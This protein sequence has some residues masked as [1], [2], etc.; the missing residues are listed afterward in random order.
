MLSPAAHLRAGVVCLLGGIGVWGVSAWEQRRNGQETAARLLAA[1]SNQDDLTEQQAT[2]EA[3]AQL[4]LFRSSSYARRAFLQIALANPPD[5]RR[6]KSREQ[7]FEIS[8]SRVRSS[9]AHE[10]FE[11]AI[12]PAVSSSTDPDILRE[13][14][15]LMERW[16]IAGTL[17]PAENEKLA[18]TSVA[19]MLHTEDTDQIGALAYGVTEVAA[20]VR[21]AAADDLASQL[22]SRSLEDANASVN[23]ARLPALLALE[24]RLSDG[25]AAALAVQLTDRIAQEHNGNALRTLA[26]ESRGLVEKMSAPVAEGM[27]TKIVARIAAEMNPGQLGPLQSL[28]EPVRDKIGSDKA[29]ELVLQ[30]EPRI[31]LESNT[32][33]LQ[34][35]MAAWRTLASRVSGDAAQPLA[36]MLLQRMNMPA[37]ALTLSRLASALAALNAT[38]D[39]FQHAGEILIAHMRT[40]ANGDDLARLGAAVAAMRK[41][42]PEE[43]V[44]EAAGILVRRMIAESDAGAIGEMA[45]ALD[46]LDEGVSARKAY[47]F[48]TLIEKRMVSDSNSEALLNLASGFL[49]V[50][51]RAGD[52]AAVGL[53]PPLLARIRSE[54]RPAVLRT[55]A[56]CIGAFS[57]ELD[58]A[59]IRD[60]ATKLVSAMTVETDPEALRS[61]TAGL[62]AVGGKGDKTGA[63]SFNKAASILAARISLESDIAGLHELA[64]SLHA[65]KDRA[66]SSASQPAASNLAA[67][68]ADAREPVAVDALGR[69][70]RLAA[71]GSDS[72]QIGSTL[73]ARAASETSANLLRAY[74]EVLGSLPVGSIASPQLAQLDRMFAI[75]NAPCEVVT[76]VKN[77]DSAKLVRQIL[78]P[79]CFEDGWTE[80]VATL[81]E[82]TK[83]AIV[84]ED[85]EGEEG[86]A[87]DFVHLIAKDDD[88]ESSSDSSAAAQAGAQ[89][90]FNKLSAAL[91][92]LRPSGSFSSANAAI[93]AIAILLFAAGVIFLIL[94]KFKRKIGH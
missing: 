36:A 81:G 86:P 38:P 64:T 34:S 16:G 55:F 60:A 47:E 82:S 20:F 35:M 59:Q 22:V 37:D 78:N 7:A 65:L 28:L 93:P 10:L 31:V 13:G 29:R 74:G 70:L 8:L 41:K 27:A 12:L 52:D 91:D 25:R 51:E 1:F 23:D 44:E 72:A 15:A 68:I 14:F 85:A 76:R 49:A 63:E 79:L 61:L 67:R 88:D 3:Q 6:L 92:P 33:D 32:A 19:A 56:F 90:D 77:V 48:A 43:T 58:A 69:S 75:P 4:E 26:M 5:A 80:T 66:S 45:G 84:R 94:F 11:D 71:E 30:I 39:A 83:Q 57:D 46:D 24:L 62:I 50:V 21:Q 18:R 54:S 9:E 89:V 53:A 42:L 2:A 87:S 73:A 17:S 40:S